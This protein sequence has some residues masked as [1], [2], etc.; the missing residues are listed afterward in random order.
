MHPAYPVHILG[1]VVSVVT[2]IRSHMYGSV[3]VRLNEGGSAQK[4]PRAMS[5]PLPFLEAI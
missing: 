2:S 3:R 5:H 4:H 1:N